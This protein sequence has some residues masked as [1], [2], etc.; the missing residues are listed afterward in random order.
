ML[1]FRTSNS[2]SLFIRV[3]AKLQCSSVKSFPVA[4]QSLSRT[5]SSEGTSSSDDFQTGK[6]KFYLRSKAYGFIIP[7]DNPSTELWMH[8]TSIDTPHP[9]EEFPTRPYLLKG[10]SVRF[11]VQ[12]SSKGH[13]DEAVDVRF[14]NGRQIP[15]YRKNYHASVVR[16]ELERLGETVFTVLKQDL[17]VLEQLEQIK[18][19]AMAAEERISLA[20]ERQ[21]QHGPEPSQ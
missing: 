21:E 1:A 12:P 15:L 10:E 20:A 18:A 11:R 3:F 8:R 16:G 17:P 5:L 9:V 7:D 2:S 4:N 6:V 14:E 13:T 19:A